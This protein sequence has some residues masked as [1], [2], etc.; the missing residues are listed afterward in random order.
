MKRIFTEAEK[1]RRAEYSRRW[2]ETHRDAVRARAKLSYQRNRER[3]LASMKAYRERGA[4]RPLDYDTGIVA[5]VDVAMTF[6][7]IAEELGVTRARVGQIVA[8][9]LRKLRERAPNLAELLR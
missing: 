9:A 3:K 2:K 1:H 5:E 7:E 8:S 6:A 4:V